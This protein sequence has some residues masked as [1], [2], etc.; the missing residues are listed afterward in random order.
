MSL[1]RKPKK[2]QRRV[3]SSNADEEEDGASLDPDAEMEAPP[4]PIISGKREKEKSRKAIKPQ[5]DNSKPKALLSFADD[6]DDGEVF[7]VRK[8]SHSKKVM[9]MLD[10]ERRKKKREERA[11][12]SGLPGGENGSTQHLESSGGP[13]SGPPNSNSNPANAGRYKSA[14]DQSKS[15]KSDNHMIQTEIRT[16]DFVLVVKKSET[17]E[18]ILNGRAAL[19][20]GREDMSDEEDQQ[21]E[22]GG[23]DKTRH[24]FSKPEHLKQMLE[25]GSIPD[26][27]MIHAARKRRQRA[28]EQGAGDYIPIEEPKEPAKLS[29]RLPCEDVEGDQS[30]DE[31]RMD[32]NDITGRKEREER[33]EQFYAVENDSTDGDSDR[34]MNE[35][36]NQQIR[37]GVTAA[38]LVHSQHETVLSRFMIKPATPGIGTGMDDGDST[39]AQS[40]STLLEQ[41]YAK[42]ALE[43]TN[44][45]AA[46]RSSVKAK[47]EKAKAAALRTPQE[48]LAAIQSR[49]SELKERSA[50]HSATMARIS[51]EL[52]ALKLQQLECQQNAPTAA[53]K[54]KFYQEIKCY[55]NDLVDCLSE[56][57]P[58]IYDLE[59]RALQQYGKNQRYLVNRRRQDV[60]DQAK[61]IAESA[62]P[63]TAAS[64]RAPE[65]EEQ[66][67]R[68]AER[69]GRRTRRRC[70]RER[71]DLLSS[72]LDGMSSDDEI[73]D[74]QQELSVTTMTQIES[75]SV[76]AFEDVTDDFSKIELILIKFFAWRK[77]D[78]SS[79]QDAF[80]SLCLPKLLA[81]LVRHE[82]VLWSPLL[83]EYEDIEN[84]RWYQACMLYAS[85]ADETVEQ[86]KIDPDINL[87]PALIEKIV[88]PKVTALVTECWDPL[89]TTQTLRLVGFINR[90]GREFPLS[91]TNKQLNKLFESIMDRMRLALENDV[92]IPIFPKQVQEAKTSFFQ[93]QFCSGLKLFRNFLSWQGILA[94]KLLRELAIGALL[95]RYLLLAMRVCTPNDAINKAYIIVNT[96]PTV[97]LLPNSETLKNMELFIGYIK[98][99]LENC[100]ASNPIFMQSSDKAKQILQRL[101][102]L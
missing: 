63:V 16:D 74:Q 39:A 83:D 78:M 13:S 79:Y 93:R 5:E 20:A 35:W 40:T 66:V 65:Y 67:R 27:A 21:S 9:R 95:N 76:E 91:G 68:A 57:A 52:K 90:L 89:S 51:T 55:V 87:V 98:Q 94:D 80:V 24:R 28:R 85:Q 100:D 70:E 11:E 37:K 4:P 8:S 32:M 30:D 49:L 96:L 42:N 19:C 75:Q 81:P 54:Y 59:K 34:E 33:R 3:F 2:I 86:L 44:L 12:N 82:L 22:D 43:R 53:A 99:T 92:F 48:I 46:V 45:A 15:K 84:M 29:N 61:E 47:K 18:A 56:K 25:S 72:H 6:E 88:L 97:W 7:Q 36:E 50:D 26:A 41:A 58:V 23:H 64:R 1:F 62:K 31:E 17:P 71:N 38:Q 101:H 60:R 69:E 10:K 73:A 77:T 102:S 14:S